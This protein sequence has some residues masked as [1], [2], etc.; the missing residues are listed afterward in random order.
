[1]FLLS[2]EKSGQARRK[3]ESITASLVTGRNSKVASLSKVAQSGKLLNLSGLEAFL[4]HLE[5]R[6][7]PRGICQGTVS[8]F[9]IKSHLTLLQDAF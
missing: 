6:G 9:F 4:P 2:S 8:F 7:Q 3:G 1:M 5:T